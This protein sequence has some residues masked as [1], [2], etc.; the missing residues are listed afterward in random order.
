MTLIKRIFFGLFVVLACA[1]G[2]WGYIKIKN[3]KRPQKDAL[4]F[5]PDSCLVYFRTSDFTELNKQIN[6][7]SLIFDNLNHDKGISN[8]LNRLNTFDSIIVNNNDLEDAF[9]K[10]TVHFA[11]YDQNNWLCSLNF[12]RLGDEKEINEAIAL[13][14][15]S[16][17]S[18]GILHS[19]SILDGSVFYYFIKQGAFVLSNNKILIGKTLV[20]SVASFAESKVYKN[21]NYKITESEDLSVTINHGLFQKY[22]TKNSP[23]LNMVCKSGYSVGKITVEP[24]QL[25]LNGFLM[26]DSVNQIYKLHNE[27]GSE[28]NFISNLPFNTV[29]F[30]SVAHSNF[31]RLMSGNTSFWKTMSDSALYNIKSAFYDNII[32]H[33][34]NF[35]IKGSSES[36]FLL[37][38][39]DTL[40]AIEQFSFMCDSAKKILPRKIYSI[41]NNF[42]TLNLFSPFFDAPTTFVCYFNSKLYFAESYQTLTNI[43]SNI[44]ANLTLDLNKSFIDYKNQNLSEVYNYCFYIVPE[45]NSKSAESFYPLKKSGYKNLKHFS[46]TLSNGQAGFKFRTNLVYESGQEENGQNVL[47]TYRLDTSAVQPPQGFLNYLTKENEILVQDES[48]HLYLVNA[49][50]NKL[51]K[52]NLKEP[53]LSKIFIADIFKNNKLQMLFNTRNYLHLI[54]RNGKYV[55]GYPVKLPSE[56]TSPLAV[57]DYDNDKNYRLLIAC[58]NKNIYNYS[59]YGIK[60]QGYKTIITDNEV[61][62]PVQYVKVGLSDY[63]VTIDRLG[64]IYTYSRKGEERIGLKNKAIQNCKAFYVDASN[65]IN[66]TF[67]I[68]VDEN[69]SLINKI[70][71]SDKKEIIKVS[72]NINGATVYFGLIDDNRTTDVVFTLPDQILAYD[73]NGNLIYEKT[74]NKIFEKSIFYSDENNATVFSYSGSLKQIITNDIVTQRTKTLKATTMPFVSDLF[75]NGKKYI[76][77]CNNNTLNCVPL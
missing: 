39:S 13:R 54:D 37:G 41:K 36:A 67:L 59:I 31:K 73:L 57:Y 11:L 66:S 17:K 61:N 8:I 34:V 69:N 1:A 16:V 55:Q 77:Y 63:L 74:Q 26:P 28:L 76:I 56:A 64:K 70:S 47:W 46:Y 3:L 9:K 42:G 53:I 44:S 68:Y 72:T 6:S 71:F 30:A 58:K 75:S 49:K 7:Q 62:L 15:K 65:N 33:M 50:G 4:S 14:L 18:D 5:L 10:T 29:E 24:N 35:K 22:I 45:D 32:G 60:Q 2:V 38:V 25:K 40:N 27:S 19:F 12:K 43:I 52:I 23:A 51:W 20:N 21:L 48:N